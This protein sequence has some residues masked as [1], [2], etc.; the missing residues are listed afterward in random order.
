MIVLNFEKWNHKVTRKYV[1]E[2]VYLHARNCFYKW[3]PLSY[4]KLRKKISLVGETE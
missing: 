4:R 1:Y 2:R 3:T